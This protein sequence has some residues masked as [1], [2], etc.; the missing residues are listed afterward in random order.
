[1]Y[2]RRYVITHTHTHTL[3]HKY[4]RFTREKYSPCNVLIRLHDTRIRFII[5]SVPTK[6][7]Y[8]NVFENQNAQ[9]RCTPT[10][11]VF[12]VRPARYTN[13]RQR[14]DKTTETV[15]ARLRRIRTRLIGTTCGYSPSSNRRVDVA[16]WCPLT[17]TTT[18]P[19]SPCEMPSPHSSS[20]SRTLTGLD[21]F[22]RDMRTAMLL[23]G[24]VGDEN[25]RNGP[26]CL[27]GV[28]GPSARPRFNG[29]GNAAAPMPFAHDDHNVIVGDAASADGYDDDDDD[30]L[31]LMWYYESNPAASSDSSP[32][33]R[34]SI[35]S[36]NVRRHL[37]RQR[38]VFWT[39]TS[40]IHAVACVVRRMRRSSVVRCVNHEK[41]VEK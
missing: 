26:L 30:A 40:V 16:T 22:L 34:E 7:D 4:V 37:H 36:G 18:A 12:A 1:M 5:H 19:G 3:A 6:N 24:G 11:A 23:R 13:E 31:R 25:V 14:P 39:T 29:N 27:P 20:S 9:K 10:T 2:I 33:H 35:P 32:V 41:K 15:P 8:C 17:T 21:C 28:F 38:R